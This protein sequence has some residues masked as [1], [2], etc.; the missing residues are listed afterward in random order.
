MKTTESSPAVFTLV[1][2]D[3]Q[4]VAK[5]RIGRKLSQEEMR[6]AIKCFENGINW[7]EVAECAIDLAIE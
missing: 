6:T 7:Y 5:A 2:W 1:E 4:E 3:F